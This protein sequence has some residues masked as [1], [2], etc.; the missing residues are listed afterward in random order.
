MCNN[1]YLNQELRTISSLVVLLSY[2][3]SSFCSFMSTVLL[4]VSII[5]NSIAGS[6]SAFKFLCGLT[7]HLGILHRKIHSVMYVSHKGK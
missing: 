2:T 4:F 7:P 5:F 6:N 3:I 1:D